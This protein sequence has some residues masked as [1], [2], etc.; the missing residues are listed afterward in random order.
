MLSHE[1]RREVATFLRMR[2][3]RLKP[4]EVGLPPGGRRRTPGLRREE[5]AALAG[6]STEW[7][8]WLEQARDVRA[9]A[10]VL[11][12]IAGALRLEPSASRHLLTLAGYG[13]QVNGDAPSRAAGVSPHLQRLLDR[14]D[15]YPAWVYGERWDVLAW[16]RGACVVYGDFAAMQ[17][18]ERN[19]LAV[20][21]LNPAMRRMLVDWPR[22]APGIVAKVRSIYARYVD[23]PWY[24][25]I[26]DLLCERCPEFAILW[27][28]HEVYP[29]QDGVKAFDHPEAGR[30]TFDFSVLDIR[31]ERFANLSLVTYVPQPATGTYERM[32]RLVAAGQR[33]LMECEE[34]D[35]TTPLVTAL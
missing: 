12:R 20:Y 23:D 17:G 6:V 35:D 10:D 9:S 4:D 16:N 29:Y 32:E 14:L 2:R 13:T 8:T 26:I 7:Y 28:D 5:V 30:L 19:M 27:K 11:E 3:A 31:D 22:L 1:R 25:E 18:L 24:H 21:F 15:P 34:S 33:L